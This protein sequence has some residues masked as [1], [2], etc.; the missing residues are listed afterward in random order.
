MTTAIRFADIDLDR[1]KRSNAQPGRCLVRFGVRLDVQHPDH[2]LKLNLS[3]VLN[4][5]S[6]Q[7][8]PVLKVQGGRDDPL[9]LFQAEGWSETGTNTE[10]VVAYNVWQHTGSAYQLLVGWPPAWAFLGVRT[11]AGFSLDGC[12]FTP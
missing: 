8:R 7:A 11:N 10:A 5:T 6:A 12:I 2:P 1:C 3:D 9:T 4:D